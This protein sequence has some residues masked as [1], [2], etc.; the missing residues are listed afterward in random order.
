MPLTHVCMWTDEHGWKKVTAKEADKIHPGGSVSAKSGLFMCELCGQYVSLTNGRIRERYFKHSKDEESKDCPERIFG[1]TVNSTFQAGAHELPIR[2]NIISQKCFRF[3]IG[4]L[5]VPH[6]LLGKYDGQKIK[7]VPIG[8]NINPF[9]YSFSRLNQEGITYLSVGERPAIMYKITTTSSNQELKNYWPES[10]EGIKKGAFFDKTTRK[11]LPI[12]ADVQVGKEYY[13]LTK[14]KLHGYGKHIHTT[15]ICS[16]NF[17]GENWRLYEIIADTFNE[18]TA[19][20]F[21]DYHC[22]L[23]EHPIKLYPLWPRYI[24]A[25]YL[26]LHKDNNIKMFFQGDAKTKLFPI[27]P[28][29]ERVLGNALLLHFQ[30]SERQ[31]MISAGR[32]K[33]LKYVYLWKNDLDYVAKEPLVEVKDIENNIWISGEQ[34]ILPKNNKLVVIAPM[35]GEIILKREKEIIN[36][37]KL[38]SNQKVVIDEIFYGVTVE[39]LQGLDCVWRGQYLKKYNSKIEEEQ[40]LLKELQKATG[41]LISIPH[42]IGS[43]AN[44]MEKYPEIKKWLYKKIRSGYIEEKAWKLLKKK[45]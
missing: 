11:K 9:V 2:I 17:F 42:T 19:R 37:Y 23:T 1:S 41:R 28:I 7:I 40:E 27:K 18:Q 12:D 22:R 15:Q 39:I 4:F 45:F 5:T 21:L 31:Q 33:V 35:D 6:N 29:D 34:N 10:I 30:S 43:L 32:S 38:M 13:L 25:P 14:S 26:I 36:K 24:E 20:F 3:E 8:Y 44:K 16:I